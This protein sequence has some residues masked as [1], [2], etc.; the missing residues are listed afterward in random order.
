[1]SALSESK[2]VFA[3]VLQITLEINDLCVDSSVVP[4]LLELCDGVV[5]SPS[6]GEVRSGSHEVSV[7]T[8]P[9]SQAHGFEKSGV[10]NA[11]VSLP[12]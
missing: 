10:V 8:S 6:V 7:V 9:P 12:R 4:E 1:L 11:L 2:R 5:M 3:P